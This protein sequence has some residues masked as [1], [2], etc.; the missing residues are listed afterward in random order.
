MVLRT[1]LALQRPLNE[2]LPEFRRNSV[3][4]R[5]PFWRDPWRCTGIYPEFPT[6][7]QT[8]SKKIP[9]FFL[10]FTMVLHTATKI[11]CISLGFTCRKVLSMVSVTAK[12]AAR[13][14]DAMV[15]LLGVLGILE[16]FVTK[17]KLG[18]TPKMKFQIIQDI[19]GEE[20]HTLTYGKPGKCGK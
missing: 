16:Q 12:A 14:L 20:V 5:I 10:P 15:K 13:S 19:Q 3:E 1:M 6:E 4:F 9:C 18:L 17:V 11:T 2:S 8:N 7:G